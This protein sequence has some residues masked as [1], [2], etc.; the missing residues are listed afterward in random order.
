MGKNQNQAKN[1]MKP[2][3]GATVKDSSTEKETLIDK[4]AEGAN[5]P[6]DE[7]R[8]GN[9]TGDDTAGL[10]ADKAAGEGDTAGAGTTEAKTSA[11]GSGD[12]NDGAS[13]AAKSK[14]KVKDQTPEELLEDVIDGLLSFGHP[15]QSALHAKPKVAAEFEVLLGKAKKLKTHIEVAKSKVG[16][17]GK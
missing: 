10:D 2:A 12:P 1:A 6:N 17:A 9:E 8:G 15:L 5:T 16:K 4:D 3:E 11:K 7:D 13:A 14:E